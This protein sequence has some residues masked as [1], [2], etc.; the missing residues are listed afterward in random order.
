MHIGTGVGLIVAGAILYWAVDADLPY[1]ADGALGVILMLTGVVAVV[2]AAVVHGQRSQT[3]AG[4]GVGLIMGGAVLLW[5]VDLDLP[6]VAEAPLGLILMV[7]GIIAV[8]ATVAM[9]MQRSRSREV[10]EHRYVD[11]SR[12]PSRNLLARLRR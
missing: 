8:V 5:A 2:A 1:V 11:G 12:P 4:T 7:A 6:Y 9:T 10:V 3:G